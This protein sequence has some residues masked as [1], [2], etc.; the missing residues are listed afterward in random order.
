MVWLVFV[1]LGLLLIGLATYTLVK[2]SKSDGQK[3]SGATPGKNNRPI[4]YAAGGAAAALLLGAV[5]LYSPL[6]SARL[7]EQSG[8]SGDVSAT[9]AEGLAKQLDKDPTPAGFK[10]LANMHFMAGKYD[11][12]VAAYHRA[13]ELGADDS[14]TWSEFGEAIV[15]ASEGSVAPQA[16][17]A[18][19]NA[20][21]RD[22]KDARARYYVGMAQAQIGN[23]RQAVAVWRD[24]EQGADPNAPWLPMVRQHVAAFSEQ[25][26][27]DP[28]SVAPAPPSVEALR[29]AVSAM[30]SASAGTGAVQPKE[31]SSPASNPPGR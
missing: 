15:M 20:I 27:F 17:A 22:P 10:R 30:N 16:L 3:G 23:F 6:G 8:A 24:L 1:G 31:S 26:G 4:L 5:I 14:G 11:E 29:A 25:G 19:A 9:S 2:S 13:I 18:F 7:L 12:A 28:K 21:S